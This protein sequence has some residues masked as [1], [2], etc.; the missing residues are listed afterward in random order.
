MESCY[1]IEGDSLYL[2]VKALPGAARNQLGGVR[3]GALRVKVAAAPEG[4]RANRELCA[5]L[6]KLLGCPKSGALL[7]AGEKSRQK[8]IRLPAGCR[9]RLD[10]LLAGE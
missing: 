10:E 1:R 8:L 3:E 9:E 6:A 2:S 4:G 7:A 5:Y